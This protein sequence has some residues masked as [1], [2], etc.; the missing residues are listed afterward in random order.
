MLL[1]FGKKALIRIFYY[2]KH[3][4]MGRLRHLCI[5]ELCGIMVRVPGYRS[6][7]P[8]SILGTT[9]FSQKQWV[10]NEVNSAS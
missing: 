6:R 8:G 4:Q 7:G 9:R 2:K 10:C 3:I 1:A 5:D